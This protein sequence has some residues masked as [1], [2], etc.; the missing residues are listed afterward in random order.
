VRIPGYPSWIYS[1]YLVLS[2]AMSAYLLS[3]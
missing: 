1:L 2:V 3:R